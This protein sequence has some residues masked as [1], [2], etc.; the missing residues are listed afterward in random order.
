M[1]VKPLILAAALAALSGCASKP[2]PPAWEGDAKSSLDGFMDDFLRGESAAADAEFARARRASASTGRFDVV[3]Q[4]ELVRCGVKAAALDYECPGFAAVAND[5]TP[6]QRAYAAYLDGRWQGLDT[7]LLP[8]QHRA[9]VASGSL[10]GVADP[11]ARLVAAGALLKAGRITPADI[12]TAV[13]TASSQGW[14]RPLL[15]WLGVQEQRAR[16]AGD[17]AAVERIRRRIELATQG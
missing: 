12:A 3:A 15:A 16:A 11:L 2:Q 10:A 6:A 5:A 17:T 8:E 13:D 4:A 14:R 7:S 1:T 9:V